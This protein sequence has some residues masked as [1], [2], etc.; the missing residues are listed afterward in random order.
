MSS[1]EVIIVYCKHCDVSAEIWNEEDEEY[2]ICPWCNGTKKIITIVNI[3][4]D[5]VPNE[6][7]TN[8]QT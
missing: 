5:D 8:F 4:P 6:N 1:E 7:E 2:D 3:I